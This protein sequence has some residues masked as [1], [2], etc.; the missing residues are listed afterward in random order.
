MPFYIESFFYKEKVYKFHQI[1]C[2]NTYGAE[3]LFETISQILGTVDGAGYGILAVL[4]NRNYLY[5]FGSDF[6]KVTAP[7]PTFDKLRFRF[8]F[9]RY[10]DKSSDILYQAE[11]GGGISE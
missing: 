5:G 7:V 10:L 2:I 3:I 9:H 1:Y 4:W 8:W 6:W 11:K